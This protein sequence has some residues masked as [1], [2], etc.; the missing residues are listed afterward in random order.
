MSLNDSTKPPVNIRI[1]SELKPGDVGYLTYLH[2]VIYASERG[3]DH[4]FEAYVARPLA[5]FAR[6][7]M[8]EAIS[9]CKKNGYSMI[10]L[11]TTNELTAAARLYGL[12]GFHIT[13]EITHKMWGATVTEQRYELT[14]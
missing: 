11:W 1:R 7:Q 3:W 6:A 2:G 12:F 10:Y 14:F 9:F 4:T 5:E 8:E 13:Q